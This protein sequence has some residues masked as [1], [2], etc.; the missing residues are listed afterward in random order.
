MSRPL[1]VTAAAYIGLRLAGKF[2]D[3]LVGLDA[4]A[5]MLAEW[6]RRNLPSI[7]FE[8]GDAGAA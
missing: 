3:E 4:L 5:E 6:W 8:R 2:V 1:Y 7:H